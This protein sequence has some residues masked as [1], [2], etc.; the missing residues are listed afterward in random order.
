MQ[1]T[2]RKMVENGEYKLH[3]IIKRMVKLSKST[4]K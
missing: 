1:S 3:S 4:N 2:Y